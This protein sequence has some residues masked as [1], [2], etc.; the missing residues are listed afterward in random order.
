MPASQRYKLRLAY[1]GT[2]YHGWQSQSVTENYKE[3][4]PEGQGIGELFDYHGNGRAAQPS[5]KGSRVAPVSS[6]QTDLTSVYSFSASAP[7]SRPMPLLPNP[8]NGA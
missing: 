4:V 3:E 1:R 8:P 2:N 5:L 6:T 7:F